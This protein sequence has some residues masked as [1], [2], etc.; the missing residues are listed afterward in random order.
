MTADGCG[1]LDVYGTQGIVTVSKIVFTC[2]CGKSVAV[3]RKFAGRRGRCPRCDK[4]V[5]IPVEGAPTHDAV[6]PAP[7]TAR[8]H[9]IP[10]IKPKPLHASASEALPTR[11]RANRL[12]AGKVCAI[13][14][15]KIAAGN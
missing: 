8:S 2:E 3:D 15:T 10:P 7:S 5:Q 12:I 6:S 9:A 14:Q 1:R 13:C 11:M 4:V